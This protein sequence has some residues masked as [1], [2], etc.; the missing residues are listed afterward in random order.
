MS[1]CCNNIGR[2]PVQRSSKSSP[3]AGHKAELSMSGTE[4]AVSIVVDP[5][6]GWTILCGVVLAGQTRFAPQQ[7]KK[8]NLDTKYASSPSRTG[9][10]SYQKQSKSSLNHACYLASSANAAGRVVA[11]FARFDYRCVSLHRL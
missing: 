3:Q 10:S 6:P 1:N 8:S 2:Q 9:A 7:R 4:Q 5:L 11:G